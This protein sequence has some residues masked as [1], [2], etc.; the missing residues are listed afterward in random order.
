MK[1]AGEDLGASGLTEF[2]WDITYW[3]WICMVAACVFGDRAW[4]L[5]LAVPMYSVYLAWTT[6]FGMKRGLTGFAGMAGEQQDGLGAGGSGTSKR[7]QKLEKRGAQ[8]VQYR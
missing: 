6:F 7:Q 1:S 8:R 4:W 2:M 3:T 5:Y